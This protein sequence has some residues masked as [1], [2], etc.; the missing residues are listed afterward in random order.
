MKRLVPLIFLLLTSV[1]AGPAQ[2]LSRAKA[3][4]WEKSIVTIE[5]SRKQYDYYQ[6]WTRKTSRVQKTGVVLSD[7]QILTTADELYDRTLVRLQK[8]GRGRWWPCD[9][10]WVDYHANLALVTSTN[11]NFWAG[12]NP[13]QLGG[14]VADDAALQILRWREGNLEN[15]HAEFTQFT[16]REGQ[17]AAI[18]Q[19]VLEADSDIQ[20]A[21]WSEMVTANSHVVGILSSQD[22]RLCTAIPASFIKDILEA[23][24][25]NRYQGLGYFHFFWQGAQNL[26][27]LARLKL[28]GEPRGVIVSS[29]PPRPDGGEQVIRTQD[30]IL[31]VDG[32]DMD[33]QGDYVDPQYGNIMLE[34]LATRNRWAGDDVKMQIWRDGQ[35]TNVVYRLPK[36]EYSISIVPAATFDQ[37]PEYLILGGLVFQPLTDSYLQSWGSDWRRRSPFRL[38]Y[39]HSEQP[40]QQRPALVLMSQVLPDAYNIGYQEQ[41]ALVLDKVNGQRI[42]RMTELRQALE[43]PVNGYHIL[44]FM[45]SDS[46]RKI[47]LAAG[48]QE[49]DATARVL[50]RYGIEEPFHFSGKD[51]ETQ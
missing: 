6:P 27:S 34:N 26:A 15:R 40:T 36:F 45:Q 9:V 29:V 51:A 1:A 16:V 14:S 11:E 2:E 18:N 13:A 30:V 22:G 17:L 19:P 43:K 48:D 10:T 4:A 5:A 25:Q 8:N 21:G 20:N 12:L 33:I 35:L 41:R 46:L 42:S 24:R 44:E 32:F 7:R 37:D 39:Y 31:N 50:Q 47:V 38:N 23:R 49:K 3:S 28:P